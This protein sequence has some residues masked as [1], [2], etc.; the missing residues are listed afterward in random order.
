MAGSG[1]VQGVGRQAPATEGASYT[2]SNASSADEGGFHLGSQNKVRILKL[3][4]KVI[5]TPQGV[6]MN[7]LR[8]VGVSCLHVA[9]HSSHRWTRT[10]S[11][12][13]VLVSG[14]E[15]PGLSFA[16][17]R[18]GRPAGIELEC[19]QPTEP[20]LASATGQCWLSLLRHSVEIQTMRHA[21]VF[22]RKLSGRGVVAFL[23]CMSAS[24]Q[25]TQ[26]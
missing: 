14:C 6:P 5:Q 11:L 22:A 20:G 18:H 15:M 25:Q 16:I 23:V 2:A 17:S 8:Y 26:L 19:R 9:V 3:Y 13:Y 1:T 7:P 10:C 24:R 4:H 12:Y 21:I